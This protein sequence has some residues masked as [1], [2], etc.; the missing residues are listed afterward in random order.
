[1]HNNNEDGTK[2]KK[3]IASE[4]ENVNE[5]RLELNVVKSITSVTDDGVVIIHES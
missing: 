2:E 5:T 3:R 4:K 1:M